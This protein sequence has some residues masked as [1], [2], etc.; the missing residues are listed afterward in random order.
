MFDAYVART[1]SDVPHAFLN[2]DTDH[3][4]GFGAWL[5]ARETA[6]AGQN[7]VSVRLQLC[8]RRKVRSAV[9]IPQRRNNLAEQA[10]LEQLV[11]S[12]DDAEGNPKVTFGVSSERARDP[13]IEEVLMAP[14]KI[15]A[16]GKKK[17]AVVFD[18]VQRILEYE[19]D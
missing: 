12:P 8:G 5:L 17:V 18:E 14:A 3:Q 4:F 16:H 7:G 2:M 9:C 13:E 1:D 11:N 6:R 15:A 19:D 10:V